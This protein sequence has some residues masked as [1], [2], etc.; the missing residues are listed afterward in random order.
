MLQHRT[1]DELMTRKVVQV[2]PDTP[3]KE[4][5]RELAEN[6][7]T[8][9]PVVARDG[10]VIGV[11]SEADLMRKA[12]DQPDPFGRPLVPNLEAWER[13]KAEGAR[14]EELMSA[15]PVCAR[16]EWNVVETARLMSVQGV[17]R[18]PVVDETDK[19][20]GIISRADILRVFLRE[21]AAIREEIHRD[22]LQRTLGLA[23]SAVTVEVSQGQVTLNGTVEARSMIPVIERLCRSVDGVVAV[24]EHLA[25]TD[26]DTGGRFPAP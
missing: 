10:R 1:V 26:D 24:H 25:Y 22:L 2:R 23:R 21:D 19:L 20:V 6:D 14:A 5:V 9:V 3:F 4:I 16:P 17:K 15:P 7:V 18:L 13:A 8:A 11:V 12:A